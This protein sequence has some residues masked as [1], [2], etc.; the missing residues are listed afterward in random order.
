M[1][2]FIFTISILL[3]PVFAFATD[4]DMGG[5]NLDQYAYYIALLGLFCGIAFILGLKQ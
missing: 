5:M 2:K 1:T 4:C 3:I